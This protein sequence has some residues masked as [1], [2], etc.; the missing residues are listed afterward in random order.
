M[1]ASVRPLR[2]STQ[3]NI[4]KKGGQRGFLRGAW[5]QDRNHGHLAVNELAEAGIHLRHF[6]GA[7]AIFADEHGRRL[8]C[9]D[10][11]L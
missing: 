2:R 1:P 4:F 10:D 8:G 6:P 11:V 3:V 7:E 9:F 5:Q